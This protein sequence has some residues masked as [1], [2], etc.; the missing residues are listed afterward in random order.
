MTRSANPITRIILVR[1]F[2]VSVIALAGHWLLGWPFVGS[3]AVGLWLTPLLCL[4]FL[5]VFVASWSWGLPI[6]THLPTRENSVALTFDDGPSS[7]VTPAI[8]DALRAHGATATFFVLGEAIEHHPDLLRRIIAER[9]TVGIHAYHHRALVL[10]PWREVEGEIARTKNAIRRACPDAPAPR[11]FR[12]PHGFKT[13]AMPWLARR[14]GCRMVAWTRSA[15]DYDMPSAAQIASVVLKTVRPGDILLLHD[16]A[17]NA[18]TAQALPQIL[19]GLSARGFWFCAL[20]EPP[21]H[22]KTSPD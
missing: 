2:Q 17:G 15:R 3:H 11:L 22:E 5:F 4:Y 10:V 18:A 7:D 8:L 16:G 9:H 13:V 6:L 21:R 14:A 19:E 20:P 12:P 1:T